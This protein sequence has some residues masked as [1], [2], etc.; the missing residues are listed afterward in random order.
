M[1]TKEDVIK[2]EQRH[3]M[4]DSNFKHVVRFA[5]LFE[6]E[7]LKDF[8]QHYNQRPIPQ[9]HIPMIEHNIALQLCNTN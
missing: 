1:L 9:A 8:Y 6:V 5:D 4:L 3:R 2:W 7:F